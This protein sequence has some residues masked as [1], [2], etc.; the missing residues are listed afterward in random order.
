MGVG[1]EIRIT[2]PE[3]SDE[4]RLTNLEMNMGRSRAESLRNL[5]VRTGVDDIKALCAILIQTD[6]FGTSVGQALRTS[7][8]SLRTKRRQR[9]EEKAA[10][11]PV[12]MIPPL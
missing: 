3:L 4:L 5:G 1:K 12:K 10:K 6:R 11:L 2:H 7:S 9:A 8:E